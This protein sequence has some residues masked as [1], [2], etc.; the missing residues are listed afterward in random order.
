M[1]KCGADFHRLRV[2]GRISLHRP[3]MVNY[4]RLLASVTACGG[5]ATFIAS[6]ARTSQSRNH[7]YLIRG[8]GR[9]VEVGF[10]PGAYGA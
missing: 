8:V 10:P 9:A 5:S 3:S 7:P 2:S 6:P 4:Y 1:T